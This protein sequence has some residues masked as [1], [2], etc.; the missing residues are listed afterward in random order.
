M[1][2]QHTINNDMNDSIVPL[3]HLSWNAIFAGV[4]FSIIIELL[5]LILGS[6]IGAINTLNIL[7]EKNY[8]NIGTGII[9][10]IIISMLVAIS[11]G[12][13]ISG[14]LAKS[15]G[16]IHGILVWSINTL[17]YFWFLFIIFSSAISNT[18]HLISTG[19]QTISNNSGSIISH[20]TQPLAE[21]TMP[22]NLLNS[23]KEELEQILHWKSV[24]GYHDPSLMSWLQKIIKSNQS[25]L[26]ESDISALRDLIKSHSKYSDQ[27][28]EQ[29]V[30]QIQ[31]IYQKYQKIK[32][33]TVQKIMDVAETTIK[34]IARISWLTFFFLIFE[35]F[36]A[37]FMG[38]IGSR[39]RNNNY[40]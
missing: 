26:Q 19:L 27:K 14:R 18:M 17:I 37:A 16:I 29:L 32:F 31:K 38:L 10:W 21:G 12:A 33:Q 22:N 39:H 8:N 40:I 34:T 1:S 9:F 25:T 15:D 24:S 2:N 11:V 5:F 30:Q 4:I 35:G 23:L 3:K 7:F 20:V 6:A 13:Y 28:I 36:L